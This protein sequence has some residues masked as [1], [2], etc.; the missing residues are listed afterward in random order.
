MTRTPSRSVSTSGSASA[1]RNSSASAMLR[2]SAIVWF[3]SSVASNTSDENH[4]WPFRSRAAP[5]PHTSGDFT[6]QQ[7]RTL[8]E[9]FAEYS[10]ERLVR[11]DWMLP[12]QLASKERAEA[13]KGGRDSR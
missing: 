9:P 6:A 5:K 4:R 13:P 12:L 11:E 3:S 10:L 7:R 2:F 1:L 8:D